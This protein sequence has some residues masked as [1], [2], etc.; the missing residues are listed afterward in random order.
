MSILLGYQGKSTGKQI[1]PFSNITLLNGEEY[2]HSSEK[3]LIQASL[4]KISLPPRK[5]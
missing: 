5:S 1:K 4:Q 3:P 2:E